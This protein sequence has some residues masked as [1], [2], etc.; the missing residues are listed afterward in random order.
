[1]I[2]HQQFCGFHICDGADPLAELMLSPL[3][4][5]SG[6]DISSGSA[7]DYPNSTYLHL[8]NHTTRLKGKPGRKR[9]EEKCAKE[10]KRKYK[11]EKRSEITGGGRRR[12]VDIGLDQKSL[13]HHHQS[14]K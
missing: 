2:L 9:D 12:F 11:G 14:Q 4:L 10:E 6:G 5:G 8:S 7:P 13:H 3:E 1:M